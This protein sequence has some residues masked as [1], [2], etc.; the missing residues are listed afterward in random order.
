MLSFLPL[1]PSLPL[2]LSQK[3]IFLKSIYVHRT[4]F[5]D[6]VYFLV[7][8]TSAENQ[9]S[10]KQ[11][12]DGSQVKQQR[13]SFTPRYM[14]WKLF[15]VWRKETER[16]RSF[17][18]FP[19]LIRIS[20]NTALYSFNF[21]FYNI[22]RK[23]SIINSE[24]YLKRNQK[25][26]VSKSYCVEAF[27]YNILIYFREEKYLHYPDAYFSLFSKTYLLQKRKTQMAKRHPQQSL[28]EHKHYL[29]SE[30]TYCHIHCLSI[31]WG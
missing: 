20:R 11:N 21:L 1:S 30:Q 19:N 14:I 15:E 4:T 27:S 6:C 18:L 2:S 3:K 23:E 5:S 8:N 17:L 26:R 22:N 12:K 29:T 28:F 13:A 16:C 31:I 10:L 25:I 7:I 24:M 9:D